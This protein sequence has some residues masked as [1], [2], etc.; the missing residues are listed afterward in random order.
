MQFFVWHGSQ[1]LC[2]TMILNPSV[3]SI[4]SMGGDTVSELLSSDG[5][6]YFIPLSI[7]KHSTGT[8]KFIK[9]TMPDFMLSG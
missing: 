7:K 4:F 5:Y 3:G 6:H 2:Q 9:M 1:N 8:P